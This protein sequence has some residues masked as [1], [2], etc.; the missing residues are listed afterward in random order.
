M[1]SQIYISVNVIFSQIY[2]SVNIV[3]SQRYISANIIFSRKE[4]ICHSISNMTFGVFLHNSYCTLEFPYCWNLVGADL[5]EN[6]R[7]ANTKPSMN[8][9]ET[10]TDPSMH[11][12]K[13]NTDPFMHFRKANKGFLLPVLLLSLLTISLPSSFPFLLPV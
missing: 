7:W 5:M 9:G 13:A 4:Y 2:I 1:L 11:F 8:F 6:L 10:H 12:G 3:L